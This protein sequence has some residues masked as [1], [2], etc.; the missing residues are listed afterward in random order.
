MLEKVVVGEWK[1]ALPR[2]DA[3]LDVAPPEKCPEL[4]GDAKVLDSA[5]LSGKPGPKEW[6]FLSSDEFVEALRWPSAKSA[7]AALRGLGTYVVI[8]DSED[9]VLP[10][11]ITDHS[12]SAGHFDGQLF[13]VEVAS[14]KVVCA[15]PLS[16][17]NSETLGGGMKVGLKIGPKVGVGAE[18]PVGNLEKNADAAVKE[19]VQ[20]LTGGALH[21]K[22]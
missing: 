14:A 7:T 20:S 22:R 5:L 19:V 11:E 2:L 18:S 15:A 3:A 10:K 17:T 6:D 16:F 21:V 1:R 9:R 13:I 12:F 4:K 8:I